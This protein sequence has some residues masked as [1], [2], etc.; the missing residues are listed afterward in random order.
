ME[1][2]SKQATR[3]ELRQ[4]FLAK[5]Q[6][7]SP[8]KQAI[9]ALSI[10]EPALK[11]VEQHQAQHIAIYLAFDSEIQTHYLIQAL[12]QQG[13]S[14]YLPVMDP[15]QK[16]I[17]HF[18]PFDENTEFETHRYGIKQPRFEPT[19][20]ISPLQID[21]IFTP[22]VGCDKQNGRLGYGGGFYD[23]YLAQAQNAVSI[24]LAYSCQQVD[25]LPLESWDMPL[26]HLIVA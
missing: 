18:L 8:S 14:I 6:R 2:L 20:I 1:K 19:K 21:L 11:L 16:G 9:A 12:R 7:I 23:R 10:V 4:T 25:K 5:R 22:L 26:N 13:K 17:L 3:Q 24:G 15:V